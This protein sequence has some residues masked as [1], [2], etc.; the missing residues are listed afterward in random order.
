MASG[1][2]G[3]FPPGSVLR[4]VHS[5]RA[6]GLLYGQRA[7]A[8][9]ALAPLNFIGTREHT[10]MP[11]R[12]FQRLVRTAKMFESIFFG[13]REEADAVLTIV[14]G[15]HE[16]VKG[17]LPE[18][19]GNFPAGTPYS[20]FDPELMLWT[21]A[22]A[23]DSA[24]TFYEIFV[25]RLTDAERDEFW[26]EYVR[27]G[28]LFGMPA[29]VAPGSWA[30]FANYFED[31][32]NSPDA[33]LTEEAM[34]TGK[35]I[36]FEIPVPPLN[37]PAMRVH[38]VVMLGALPPRVRELYG[39]RYGT[40]DALAFRVAVRAL[41]AP[42]PLAPEFMRTGRNTRFFD[43]VANTERSRIAKGAPTPVLPATHHA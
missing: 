18:V 7:L 39:L 30:E 17:E 1:A 37:L 14:R 28:E 12:P 21:I 34:Y 31:R 36:M 5:E 9:G 15:M 13:S 26:S 38:N 25:A 23:A 19:A 4:R 3:Y 42:R 8:I 29:E 20:A 6:V 2:D 35:A 27:F 11:D 40:R 32:L 22:V 24:K 41:R 33:Y 43:Q 10:R 16:T